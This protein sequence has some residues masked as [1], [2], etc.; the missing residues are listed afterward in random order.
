MNHQEATAFA[1]T[2]RRQDSYVHKFLEEHKGHLVLE[3]EFQ[4]CKVLSCP[5]CDDYIV[6]ND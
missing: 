3:H 5:Q 1:E 2:Q 4:G 6:V